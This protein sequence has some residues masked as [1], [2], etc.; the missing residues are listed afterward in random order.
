MCLRTS[1][2]LVTPSVCIS[3]WSCSIRTRAPVPMMISP[4]YIR[5]PTT[6]AQKTLRRADLMSWVVKKRTTVYGMAEKPKCHT[7]KKPTT[8]VQLAI[9]AWEGL[10][11]T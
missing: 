11:A 3:G 2:A 10:S 5:P 7:K 6:T 1:T 4:Q 9:R 8:P